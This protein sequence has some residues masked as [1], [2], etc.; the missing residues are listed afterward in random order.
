MSDKTNNFSGGANK[1]ALKKG[2]EALQQKG[3]LYGNN[4]KPGG[5]RTARS[6][7]GDF[8]E[9]VDFAAKFAALSGK[10]SE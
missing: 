10:E 5:A 2:V 3:Q 7:T 6:S 9:K 8:K 4:G 1:I